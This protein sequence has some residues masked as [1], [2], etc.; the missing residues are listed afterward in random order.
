MVDHIVKKVRDPQPEAG[1]VEV[2]EDDDRLGRMQGGHDLIEYRQVPGMSV[3]VGDDDG[4]VM[5]DGAA[6]VGSALA[7]DFGHILLGDVAAGVPFDL[8]Q[9]IQ[10]R[11]DLFIDGV[12]HLVADKLL[13]CER[14][15]D[16]SVEKMAVFVDAVRDRHDG[17]L[18]QDV[19]SYRQPLM[20]MPAGSFKNVA[21][22]E[23]ACRACRA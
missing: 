7:D 23:R 2:A 12:V 15:G 18:V 16:A 14:G 3:I 20:P 22:P 6:A 19:N 5:R 1:G 17:L 11:A 9:F 21:Q 4:A 13:A 8:H 10:R